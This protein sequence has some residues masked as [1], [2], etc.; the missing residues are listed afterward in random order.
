M[1]LSRIAYHADFVLAPLLALLLAWTAP[2]LATVAGVG[3]WLGWVVGGFVVWTLLEYAVHRFVYHHVPY[4]RDVHDAHHADPRGLIGA[5]PIVA[6]ILIMAT[7]YAPASSLGAT[8]ASGFTIGAL[9]GYF[10]YMTLHHAAHHWRTT[11]GT[12][13]HLARRHHAQHHHAGVE[14]NFGITTS[15]WDHVFGTALQPRRTVRQ[16][17]PL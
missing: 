14:G 1:R 6:L 3:A 4:F 13:L 8:A 11:P 17:A 15:L 7:F 2:G 9:A 16:R 10:A 5:P 12:W